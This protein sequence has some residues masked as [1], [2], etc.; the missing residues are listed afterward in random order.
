MK[1]PKTQDINFCAT[2][3]VQ[4]PDYFSGNMNKNGCDNFIQMTNNYEQNEKIILPNKKGCSK[5]FY[6]NLRHGFWIPVLNN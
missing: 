5:S 2:Q 1:K 6:S 3:N 4:C